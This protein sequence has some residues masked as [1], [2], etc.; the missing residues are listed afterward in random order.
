MSF[1]FTIFLQPATP[2]KSS[3]A[4]TSFSKTEVE[5]KSDKKTEE[6]EEEVDLVW[7]DEETIARKEEQA[8][9]ERRRKRLEIASK[10]NKDTNN[11]VASTS[12]STSGSSKD[13]GAAAAA[14]LTSPTKPAISAFDGK[15]FE[16]VLFWLV[17]AM[18]I[19]AATEYFFTNQLA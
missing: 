11:N 2:G 6:D 16:F 8:A 4:V 19:G 7:E 9:E 13:G 14:V 17:D 1:L 12:T 15:F 18:Y 10:Y 5:T 3:T